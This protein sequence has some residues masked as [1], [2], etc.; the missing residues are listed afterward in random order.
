MHANR[1]IDVPASDKARFRVPFCFPSSI[2]DSFPKSMIVV[3][4]RERV[5]PT[6]LDFRD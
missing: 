3:L 5:L 4:W 6:L 2:G 1:S